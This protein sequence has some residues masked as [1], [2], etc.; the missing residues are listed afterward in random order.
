MQGSE[1]LGSP[2]QLRYGSEQA[3]GENQD[4][5]GQDLNLVL[6]GKLQDIK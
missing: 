3:E 2:S 6:L 1:Q 5:G 4:A